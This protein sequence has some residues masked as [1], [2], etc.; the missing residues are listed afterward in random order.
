MRDRIDQALE[1]A[2]TTPEERAAV[3]RRVQFAVGS[4]DQ[5]ADDDLDALIGRV[6]PACRQASAV[7]AQ[8][9][10]LAQDLPVQGAPMLPG[11]LR[12]KLNRALERHQAAD[13]PFAEA[14]QSGEIF[15]TLAGDRVVRFDPAT[16]VVTP[17][18]VDR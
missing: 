1:R 15:V 3:R 11:S 13:G 7:V 12:D 6:L 5:V 9:D 2:G 8:H 14:E 4:V 10:A 18:R 16:L 17:L